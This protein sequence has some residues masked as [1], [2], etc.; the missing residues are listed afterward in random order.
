MLLD[1]WWVTR[2]TRV[3]DAGVVTRLTR[4]RAVGVETGCPGH[5]DHSAEVP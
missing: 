5:G 2:L 3:R 1:R 4:V